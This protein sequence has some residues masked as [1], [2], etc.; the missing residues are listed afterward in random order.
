MRNTKLYAE[1]AD[2]SG[3]RNSDRRTWPPRSVALMKKAPKRIK[4]TPP[5]IQRHFWVAPV[6]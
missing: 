4:E 5:F 1:P 2:L 6:V 3:C